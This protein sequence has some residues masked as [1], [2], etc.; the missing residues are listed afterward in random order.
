MFCGLSFPEVF[1]RL[2][3]APDFVWEA[4]TGDAEVLYIHRRIGGA[5]IYFVSNQKLRAEPITAKFRVA[6]R[7]PELWDPVTG[8]ITRPAMFKATVSST[9]SG[10]R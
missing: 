2:D 1:E 8:T 10:C 3:L 4:K 5:D 6:G 9:A 7:Q